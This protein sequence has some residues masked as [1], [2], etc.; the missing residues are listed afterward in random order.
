M[1]QRQ[2]LDGGGNFESDGEQP[3]LSG[4]VLVFDRGQKCWNGPS[5]TLR[6]AL[7]CGPE[8]VLSAVEEPE[9]CAYTAVLETPAA[10]TAHMKSDLLRRVAGTTSE[11]GVDDVKSV[12]FRNADEGVE[13]EL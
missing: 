9:T 13:D 3:L 4:D 5:R 8:D 6:V 11:A 7:A 1:D 12:E 10:C 2:T